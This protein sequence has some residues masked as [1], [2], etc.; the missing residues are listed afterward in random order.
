MLAPP[1]PGARVNLPGLFARDAEAGGDF[2][3]SDLVHFDPLERQSLA[4]QRGRSR[5]CE[6]RRGQTNRASSG[7]AR[8]A[9][10][11]RQLL[12]LG[13][14]FLSLAAEIGPERRERKIGHGGD[15]VILDAAGQSHP[16][17]GARNLVAEDGEAIKPGSRSR[18]KSRHRPP[19]F[20]R[21]RLRF[22]ARSIAKEVGQIRSEVK[23]IERAAEII[24]GR[25]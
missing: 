20:F 21:V 3:E 14:P 16:A 9:H 4:G 13:H 23:I 19:R 22:H 25:K 2:A 18:L 6:P 12:V 24:L 1:T 11:T 10:S 5:G 15:G 7:R 17:G 8:G